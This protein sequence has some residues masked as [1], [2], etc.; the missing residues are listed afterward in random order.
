MNKNM[1][2]LDKGIRV[3]IASIFI[4]LYFTGVIEGTI[5]LVLLIVSAIFVLTSIVGICPLYS[6]LGISTCSVPSKD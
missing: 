3:L 6:I 5:G 1:S 2:G 4:V